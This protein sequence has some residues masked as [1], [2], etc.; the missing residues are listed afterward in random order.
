MVVIRY[1]SCCSFV[2][3]F[4]RCLRPGLFAHTTH[5]LSHRPVSAAIP[6]AKL[7]INN[8]ELD[9]KLTQHLQ[10]HLILFAVK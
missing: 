4:G 2:R 5:G 9:V 7:G 3:L 10:N 1:R 8:R 6:N